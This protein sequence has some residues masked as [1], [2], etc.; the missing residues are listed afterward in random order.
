MGKFGALLGRLCVAAAF[1]GMGIDIF[2]NWS[3]AHEA[4]VDQLQLVH[5]VASG[6]YCK[7]LHLVHKLSFIVLG[8]NTV[9]MS[10]CGLT[11][12][13]SFKPRLS[14]FLLMLVLVQ[15]V[16]FLHPFWLFEGLERGQS[17]LYIWGAA[18]QFGALL[19]CFSIPCKNKIEP[20]EP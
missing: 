15:E 10:L 7:L 16:F 8:F 6:V 17:I 2:W 13:F 12:L 18:V 3:Q 19:F 1:L 4:F 11:L 14:A 20:I 9:L 5:C